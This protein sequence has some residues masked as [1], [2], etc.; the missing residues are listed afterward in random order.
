MRPMMSPLCERT[1]VQ[2]RGP[3]AHGIFW[4]V[5][6][7]PAESTLSQFGLVPPAYSALPTDCLQCE[8]L[9]HPRARAVV[10]DQTVAHPDD[11]LGVLGDVVLVGDHDDRLAGVVELAEHLHDLV[12]GLGVEVAGGLVG[13]DDVGVVDQ[14][15]GDRDAL[16]LAAGEL[17]RAVVEPVVQADQPGQ[18]Q[19]PLLDRRGDLAAALVGQRELDV[20]DDRVLL[21]QVVRLEDEAD[22]AAPDLG[23]LV[24]AELGDVAVAEDVLA[25]GGSVEAAEQVE[26]R[27]LARARGAH[28]GD[29]LALIEIDRDPRRAWTVTACSAPRRR[30]KRPP[31]GGCPSRRSSDVPSRTIDG[32]VVVV[33][34]HGFGPPGPPNP[35]PGGPPPPRGPPPKLSAAV[36]ALQDRSTRSAGTPLFEQHLAL[37]LGAGGLEL[38]DHRPGLLDGCR[39]RWPLPFPWPWPCCRTRPWWR[40][41]R[42][43]R[44]GAG[45][46][47]RLGSGRPSPSSRRPCPTTSRTPRASLPRSSARPG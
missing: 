30:P 10:D 34:D 24:V 14:R 20:L 47:V 36:D 11:P 26:H 32:L 43:E 28:D 38:L 25:A 5:L 22:V 45:H 15:A 39:L 29:V 33:V 12:A 27:A 37:L 9:P 46:A 6:R 44:P 42:P 13:Q 23:Q 2:R 3:R 7:P 8:F 31:P 40:P 35:P 16:L 41:D 19:G 1:G 17:G 4:V 21:D 18:L